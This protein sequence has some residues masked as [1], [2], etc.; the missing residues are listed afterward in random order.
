MNEIKYY[1]ETVAAQVR[2]IAPDKDVRVVEVPKNGQIWT[3]ITVKEQDSNIAPNIYIDSFYNQGIAAEEVAEKVIEIYESHKVETF[4]VNSVM[5]WDYIKDHVK[6]RIINREKNEDKLLRPIEGTDLAYAAAVLV[7][8]KN[9]PGAIIIKPE[10]LDSIGVTESE[11][12]DQAI[13]NLQAAD[14]SYFSHLMDTIASIPGCPYTDEEI[15]DM[16]AANPSYCVSNESKCNAA[17]YIFNESV[18]EKINKALGQKVFVLPSS[19]HECLILPYIEGNEADL[20]TMVREVNKFQ[21]VPE[22]RLADSVYV[23]ETDTAKLTK[24]A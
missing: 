1:A 7:D 20:I 4:D 22:E 6:A 9:T 8:V 12:M 21:V 3:G 16:K 19:I 5:T 23:F 11:L 18:R 13:R 2:L 14:D 10:H 15:E 17:G 24:V